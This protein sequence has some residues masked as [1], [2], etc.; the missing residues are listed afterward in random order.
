LSDKQPYP[1]SLAVKQFLPSSH[2]I[3]LASVH[4]FITLPFVL[5][6]QEPGTATSH[7]SFAEAVAHLSGQSKTS[8]P[9]DLQHLSA[10]FVVRH[11]LA[12]VHVATSVTHG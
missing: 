1:G 3:A 4:A 6:T 10:V 8:E 11:F 5:S 9:S 12:E 7:V 2:V